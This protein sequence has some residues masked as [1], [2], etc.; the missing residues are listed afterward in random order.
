M[1]LLDTGYFIAL[2]TPDDDLY[3]RAAAWS[4]QLNEPLV[5]TEYVLLE[6]VNSFSMPKDRPSAHALIEHV[7]SDAA[8][9]VVQA[10][11]RLFEAGLRIH[12][13]R[14]D[15]EWSLTDC[16]SFALMGERSIQRALAYDHHFEQAGFEA[17]LR[18]DPPPS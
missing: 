8:C 6:C 13:G 18:K 7:R 9:E 14:P 1:I 17:L 11:P 16:I 4:L 10:S 2:F 5:V 15:K 12:R 3:E